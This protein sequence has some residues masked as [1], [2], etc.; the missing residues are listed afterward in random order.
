MQ[1]KLQNVKQRLQN[2]K[3]NE[4][5]SMSKIGTKEGLNKN[6]HKRDLRK[7]ENE[8]SKNVGM[9]NK[10]IFEESGCDVTLVKGLK[11]TKLTLL[12]KY[13]K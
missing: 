6:N 9:N 12:S 4:M 13:Y 1:I 7:I 11:A 3:T 10:K 5:K 2:N 8:I